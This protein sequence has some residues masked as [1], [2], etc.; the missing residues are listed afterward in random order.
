MV[1]GNKMAEKEKG[2]GVGQA[3][4][5]GKCLDFSLCLEIKTT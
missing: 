2:K 5:V 4:C 3:S 1:K